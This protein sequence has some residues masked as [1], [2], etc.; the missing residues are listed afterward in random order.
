MEKKI[1][2]S[3]KVFEKY[4]GLMELAWGEYYAKTLAIERDLR[5]ESGIKD[6]E[7]V[8]VDG[9]IV[10]IGNQSKTMKLMQR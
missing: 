6:I 3:R 8:W 1:K 7:F 10:G 2:I 4:M 5:D 9:C